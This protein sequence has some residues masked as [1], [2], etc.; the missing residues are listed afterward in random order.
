MPLKRTY[1]TIGMY[2]VRGKVLTPSRLLE[3]WGRRDRASRVRNTEL[4]HRNRRETRDEIIC[5]NLF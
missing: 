4:R 3:I 5:V 2:M 1:L